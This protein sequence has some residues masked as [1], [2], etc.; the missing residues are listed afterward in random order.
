MLC[1]E[2][3]IHIDTKMIKQIVCF[4]EHFV[5]RFIPIGENNSGGFNPRYQSQTLI[6]SYYLCILHLNDALNAL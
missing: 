6:D 5:V 1:H 3:F 2:L 4:L